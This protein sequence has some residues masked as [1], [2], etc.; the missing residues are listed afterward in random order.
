MPDITSILTALNTLI[1]TSRDIILIGIAVWGFR[2]IAREIKKGVEKMPEW[3]NT[4][5]QNQLKEITLK[6]AIEK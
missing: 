2:M 6:R 3:I 1:T 5:H 4:Y